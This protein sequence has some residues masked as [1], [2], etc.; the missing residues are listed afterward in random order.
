MLIMVEEHVVLHEMVLSKLEADV[1]EVVF[2][3]LLSTEPVDITEMGVPVA[4]WLGAT[5]V[6]LKRDVDGL[7]CSLNTLVL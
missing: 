3:Y 4:M 5:V 6:S 1:D 7:S 2:A